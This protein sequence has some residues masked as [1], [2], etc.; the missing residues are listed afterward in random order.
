MITTLCDWFGRH[1]RDLPWRTHRNGYTALVAESMLQQTQ[2]SRVVDRYRA[3]M[4]RFPTVRSLAA[5][6]ERE[7]LVL[8][9]G[10]GYYRRAL[11]LHAASKMIVRE[12]GGRVPRSIADL[13]RLPGV[14]RYTAG[15]IASI[16]FGA[17][18]PIVDGNVRR[19]L[20][21]W[22]AHQSDQNK[23]GASSWTWSAAARLVNT[24][25]DPGGFN[26][27]LMELGATICTPKS[28]RCHRCP[29]RRLCSARAKGLQ[30]LIPA[31]K[32]RTTPKKA[33][34]HAVIVVRRPQYPSQSKILIEQRDGGMWSGMWQ[35]PTIESHREL[36]ASEL[37]RKLS[38]P[39]ASLE[40][41]GCFEHKTTHRRILF[42]IYRARTQSRRGIWRRISDLRDL[43]MSAAQQRVLQSMLVQPRADQ[44]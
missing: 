13:R 2:V 32:P 21:R 35:V 43:P 29:V 9:D 31:P 20:A 18:E 7:V 40:E 28:P 44:G 17:P 23:K 38:I 6:S 8:W 27:A 26:E 33:N 19:V 25:R 15:A 14:G 3:F 24:A 42:H 11:N 41:W 4:R 34:H 37:K 39:I 1:G 10:L 5:G 30:E 22:F 12:F 36:S 16:V